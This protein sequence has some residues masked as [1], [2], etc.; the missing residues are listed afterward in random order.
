VGGAVVRVGDE[1]VDGSVARRLAEAQRR[2][3]G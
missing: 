2:L 3:A 1:V